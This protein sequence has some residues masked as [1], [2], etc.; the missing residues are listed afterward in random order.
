MT[1]TDFANNYS[2]EEA[3]FFL[4]IVNEIRSQNNVPVLDYEQFDIPDAEGNFLGQKNYINEIDFIFG[5]IW[6][7]EYHKTLKLEDVSAF[8]TFDNVLY[9]DVI[10]DYRSTNNLE[11]LEWDDRNNS[12]EQFFN[13]FAGETFNPPSPS[14]PDSQ[15]NTFF[16]VLN[17]E[18]TK[19][20]FAPVLIPE[21]ID[22]PITWFF[23]VKI[24]ELPEFNPAENV[25]LF[26]EIQVWVII[27]LVEG[28]DITVEPQ[29][30]LMGVFTNKN[31]ALLAQTTLEDL[32]PNDL[33]FLFEG[34]LNKEIELY[35]PVS[36]E[37]YPDWLKELRGVN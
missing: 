6:L 35:L 25:K 2:A 37:D 30:F 5:N 27:H 3:G 4:A 10:D 16:T 23:D 7:W 31:D 29:M 32:H 15:V 18:R 22:D 36:P 17:N 21:G 11:A 19:R 9:A 8:T 14:Y 26:R 24:K 28:Y 33:F 20:G 34:Q 13:E 1:N 12:I